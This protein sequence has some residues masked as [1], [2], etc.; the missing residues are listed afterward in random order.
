[1]YGKHTF[2]RRVVSAWSCGIV[3][4][5]SLSVPAAWAQERPTQVIDLRV[6]GNE[7]M[8]PEA[9][10]S[11]VKTRLGQAYSEDVIRAD[12]QA[13][14]DTGHF[15]SVVVTKTQTD[16]GIVVTFIV[17][18]RPLVTKLMFIGNKAFS[19]NKLAGELPFGPADPVNPANVNA[20]REALEAK[21]KSSGYHFATVTVDKTALA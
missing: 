5:L 2:R 3:A 8:T 1:M 14:L 7:R 12:K 16:K 17:T 20:G 10:F 11:H 15:T 21:Y 6:E 19:D 4:L 13:L 18:E 9:I